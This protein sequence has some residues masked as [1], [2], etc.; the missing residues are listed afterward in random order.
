[1]LEPGERRAFP[2]TPPPGPYR[3]R[4]GVIEDGPA[5][6]APANDQ[7]PSDL[8]IDFSGDVFPVIAATL[9]GAAMGREPS[10]GALVFENHTRQSRVF[11]LERRDWRADTVSAAE[12][13][14][15][16]A[17]RDCFESDAPDPPAAAG[18]AYFVAVRPSA[19]AQAFAQLGE[20]EAARRFARLRRL[21]EG[22]ARPRAGSI[23]QVTGARLA[24]AFSDPIEALDF[25][26]ALRP[27][28]A[29]ALGGGEPIAETEWIGAGDGLERR[30]AEPSATARAATRLS[31]GLAG[32]PMIAGAAMG[33]LELGGAALERA[34]RLADA[35]DGGEIALEQALLET[36]DFAQCLGAFETIED[37]LGVEAD[38]MIDIL[39]VR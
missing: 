31:I 1:M 35:A 33:R 5:R 13:I 18:R 25:A 20:L 7:T 21:A 26:L 6:A 23:V 27:L 29:S 36:P 11:A 34:E 38:A 10:D 37:A 8:T 39:R 19:S 15:L 4:V 3:V 28:G 17:H 24:A 14:L 16:Q 30:F 9:E 22:A 2:Y 12:L 32:G